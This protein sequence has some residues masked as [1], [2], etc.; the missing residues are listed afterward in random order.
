MKDYKRPGLLRKTLEQRVARH[1]HHRRFQELPR[2]I[3]FLPLT[4]LFLMIF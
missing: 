4:P 2:L 1:H 3:H